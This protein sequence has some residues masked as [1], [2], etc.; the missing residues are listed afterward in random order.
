MEAVY[1]LVLA[2]DAPMGLI[3]TFLMFILGI[4]AFLSIFFSL[5]RK[6]SL[7]GFF[8]QIPGRSKEFTGLVWRVH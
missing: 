8:C 1:N 3:N 7:V 6:K 2:S 5:P 4:D